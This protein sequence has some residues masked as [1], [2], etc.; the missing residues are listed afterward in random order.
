IAD[1]LYH[2]IADRLAVIVET[3]VNKRFPV[4]LGYLLQGHH[5]SK[6]IEWILR[7]AEY[8]HHHVAFTAIETVGRTVLSLP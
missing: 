4:F 7:V 5:L 1:S 8:I 6:T 3:V 2:I